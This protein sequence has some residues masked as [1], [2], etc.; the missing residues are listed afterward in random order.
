MNLKVSVSVEKINRINQILTDDDNKTIIEI[1]ACIKECLLSFFSTQ[2]ETLNFLSTKKDLLSSSFP[3]DT[4]ILSDDLFNVLNFYPTESTCEI[5]QFMDHL[6]FQDTFGVS[7]KL[8][9][10][11]HDVNMFLRKKDTAQQL[12]DL[13]EE[14]QVQPAEQWPEYSSET[15]EFSTTSV[16]DQYSWGCGGVSGMKR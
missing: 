10:T 13:L 2:G 7:Y 14:R 16:Q 6:S 1:V 4:A 12:L 11:K 3:V 8:K 15:P 5:L 9:I